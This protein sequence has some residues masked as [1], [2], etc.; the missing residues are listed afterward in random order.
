MH[1]H[2]GASYERVWLQHKQARSAEARRAWFNQ[3]TVMRRHFGA[4][5][6]NEP[7]RQPARGQRWRRTQAAAKC[8]HVLYGVVEL[9]LPPMGLSHIG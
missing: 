3:G 5:P 1:I 8:G 9:A 7:G 4:G 2:G 6:T